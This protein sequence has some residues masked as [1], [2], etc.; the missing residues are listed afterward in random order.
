MYDYVAQGGY[1]EPIVDATDN[2]IEHPDDTRETTEGGDKRRIF[3]RRALDTGDADEDFVIPLDTE[4]EIGYA[5]N[6]YASTM[7]P[8]TTHELVGGVTVTLKSDGT[9]LWGA[10]LP[11]TETPEDAVDEDSD[12]PDA[13]DA[14]DDDDEDLTDNEDDSEDE[15]NDSAQVLTTAGALLLATTTMLLTQF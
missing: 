7:S 14:L 12:S 8:Y 10:M 6:S 3:V 4:F 9:P 13:S 15:E 1:R 5:Y 2:L 11:A